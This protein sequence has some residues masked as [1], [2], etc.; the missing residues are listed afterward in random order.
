M[1]ILT[2]TETVSVTNEN[3]SGID[4]RKFTVY[5]R[6][7]IPS[8]F[9]ADPETFFSE[10]NYKIDDLQASQDIQSNIDEVYSGFCDKM[11]QEMDALLNPRTIIL[12]PSAHN[13]RKR[14]KKPWWNEKLSKMWKDVCTEERKWLRSHGKTENGIEIILL[15]NA[16]Y[17]TKSTIF[18]TT[19]LE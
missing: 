8:T 2:N 1:D 5:N 10:N 3:G 11:K 14:I 7:N 15:K 6:K 13:K 19:T 12:N 16:K 4:A 18:Q 9:L 17:L